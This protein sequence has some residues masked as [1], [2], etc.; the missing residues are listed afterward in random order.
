M[1]RNSSKIIELLLLVGLL[2]GDVINNTNRTCDKLGGDGGV[3]I[4]LLLLCAPSRGGGGG[5]VTRDAVWG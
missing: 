3:I 2:V 1:R 4:I 5:I